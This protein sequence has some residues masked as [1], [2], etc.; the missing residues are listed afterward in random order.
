[1]HDRDATMLIT[2]SLFVG[3]G[4]SGQRALDYLKARILKAFGP[5]G[6]PLAELLAADFVKD[7]HFLNAGDFIQMQVLGL[8]HLWEEYGLPDRDTYP[9]LRRL[10]NM[11]DGAAGVRV[12][13]QLGYRENRLRIRR[14]LR[15]KITAVLHRAAVLRVRRSKTRFSERERQELPVW[16][17][18]SLC[19]G[20]GAGAFLDA[21]ADLKADSFGFPVCLHGLFFLPNVFRHVPEEV[22]C[23]IK[24][25]ADAALEELEQILDGTVYRSELDGEEIQAR[26]LFDKV[27]LIDGQNEVDVVLDASEEEAFKMAAE[28]LFAWLTTD[29]SDRLDTQLEEQRLTTYPIYSIGIH[30]LVHPRAQLLEV[31][32]LE[33]ALGCISELL[34]REGRR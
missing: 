25:T 2:P 4:T 19:G 13:G 34:Q 3:L 15:E 21:A 29:L 28:F 26:G 30:R 23:R 14:A 33:K 11:E 27:I 5:E 24:A 1:M 17:V 31:A 18:C 16:L 32:K 6:L 9:S 12:L 10:P 7:H 22:Y 20:T 8:E